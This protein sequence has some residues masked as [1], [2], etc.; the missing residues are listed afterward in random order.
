MEMR[1]CVTLSGTGAV[2][3]PAALTL[4]SSAFAKL[5]QEH[6]KPCTTLFG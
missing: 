2:S 5:H 4:D 3:A 1:T 6:G